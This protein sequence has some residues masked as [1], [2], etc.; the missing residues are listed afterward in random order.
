MNNIVLKIQPNYHSSENTHPNWG[1]GGVSKRIFIFLS[2]VFIFNKKNLFMEFKRNGF[3]IKGSGKDQLREAWN[4]LGL[5]SLWGQTLGPSVAWWNQGVGSW[6]AA[7]HLAS[8]SGFMT[9]GG[10]IPFPGLNVLS[11]LMGIRFPCNWGLWE[12]EVRA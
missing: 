5:Y 12:D 1:G 8:P 6:E 3:S 7:P 2:H 9:L 11:S 10:P 4:V